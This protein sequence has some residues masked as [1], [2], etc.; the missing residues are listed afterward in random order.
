MYRWFLLRKAGSVRQGDG[1]IDAIS[2][3]ELRALRHNMRRTLFQ[4]AALG[5]LFVVLYYAPQY[6]FTTFF[7]GHTINISFANKVFTI[8]WLT[9]L[10]SIALIV[11]ELQCLALVHIAAV[12]NASLILGFTSANELQSNTALRNDLIDFALQRNNKAKSTT[13]N[14]FYGS[15]KMRLW[16]QGLWALIRAAFSNVIVKW[17]MSRLLG[18]YAIRWMLDA[19]SIPVYAVWNA[20]ASFRLL[21]QTKLTF[22]GQCTIRKWI[23]RRETNFNEPHKKQLIKDTLQQVFMVRRAYHPNLLRITNELTQVCGEI[24]AVE[25]STQRYLDALR[26]ADEDTRLLINELV[27]Y[28]LVFSEVKDLS[29]SKTGKQLIQSGLF[30]VALER[31]HDCRFQVRKGIPL[32]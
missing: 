17:I 2:E 7:A 18:R 3:S 13:I 11:A 22:L 10:W 26:A 24:D 15:S 32:E 19:I 28:A 14:P 27:I 12:R 31:L 29:G 5:A 4:S 8:E 30:S 6:V 20:Y 25:F 21:K 9:I 1:T 23:S 16:L